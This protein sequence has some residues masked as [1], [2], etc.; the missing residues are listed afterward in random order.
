MTLLCVNNLSV[1][2]Q[3]NSSVAPLSLVQNMSFDIQKGETF[4]LVGESG[5]GKSITALSILGLLPYPMAS[6][7]TGEV[8]FK[9]QDLLNKGENFL[10]SYRG[11]KIGMIFQEPMT[12]LNPLHSIE[13]QISE[14]LLIHKGLTRKQAKNRVLDLLNLVGFKEGAERLTA[15]PHQLSGG[16]R[17]RVMIA[18]ALACEPELLIADEPTTALDVTIQVGILKLIKSLQTD[19]NMGLLLISHDLSMVSRVADNI[20]VMKQGNLVEKGKTRHV[21]EN[22]THLYTKSLIEAEPCGSPAPVPL[23][24]SFILRAENLTVSYLQKKPSFFSAAPSFLAVDDIALVLKQGE[25]LGIVG[26]SGSGKSTLAYALLKL[27]KSTGDIFF[28]NTKLQQLS[29][30]QLRPIRQ[31]MQLIFQD[32]FSSLNPRFSIEQIVEEGLKVHLSLSKSHREAAVSEALKEVGLDSSARHRYPHEFS[33]GQRQRIAIARA[34]ILK[35]TLLV[36]DEPTSALDRSI[37]AEIIHLLRN[38]QEK[39]GLSY[40]FISHD[41]KVVQAM[42]HRIIVMKQG[43][44]VEYGATADLIQ[45]PKT[46]YA[47]ALMKA[48]FGEYQK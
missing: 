4:A 6:H 31:K 43:K 21:L 36:L 45:N 38:L 22:P 39:N 1:S 32:P 20:G 40:L 30:K 3:K 18:I 26:E 7:P 27:I 28:Q 23:E 16:Q 19:F 15:L 14:P 41:L 37:Q 25:T 47:K 8:L 5:S 46:D 9:G 42:S 2:F 35:P 34:L 44:I 12:A 24:A 13:K 11:Q 33:G 48:A 17:Q 29:A 10:K